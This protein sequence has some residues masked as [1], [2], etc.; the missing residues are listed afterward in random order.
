M[1]ETKKIWIVTSSSSTVDDDGSKGGAKG[2][3]W[4][5]QKI[6]NQAVQGVQVGVETLQANMS[7]FLDLVGSL[8]QKAE[9]KTGMELDEVELSVEITGNGEVK[10]VGSGIG[11]EGKGAI[12]LKFKRSELKNG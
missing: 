10:L 3:P 1:S 6:A 11:I 8:F 4:N 12:I 7:E 2:N 5:T 9:Q